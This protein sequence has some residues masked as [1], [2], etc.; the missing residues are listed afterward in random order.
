M[1]AA[2]L[3]HSKDVEEMIFLLEWIRDLGLLKNHRALIC[4]DA[5][6]PF[7]AVMRARAIAGDIFGSADV[8]ANESPVDGWIE[9]PKSLFISVAKWARANHESF[10]LIDSDAIPIRTGWLDLIESDYRAVG[11]KYMGCLFA[12]DQPG[13]PK[14]L[15]GPCS[16]YPADADE[17]IPAI[18]IPGRHWD[19]EMQPIIMRSVHNSPLIAHLFGEMNNPPTFARVANPAF[20]IFSLDWLNPGTM[21]FHR[22]KDRTL[23]NLLRERLGKPAVVS[24]PSTNGYAKAFFQMGRYGDLILLLPAFQEW[25]RRTGQPTVVFTSKEFGDIFEGVSYVK[26][27]KLPHNWHLQA[28]EAYRHAQTI[29]PDVI[30]IQL[31]GVG[32]EPA[33]PDSLPSYSISMWE[34]AGLMDDYARLPLV[35]D[36]R[37]DER[38]AALL[39]RWHATQKPMLLLNFH[40]RTSPFEGRDTLIPLICQ[41]LG[42]KFEFVN[43]NEVNAHRIF[44]LLGLMDAAAGLITVDTATL[45]LA[46]GSKTPYV[47]LVRG[48]GQSGSVPKGNVALRVTYGEAIKRAQEICDV[49]EAWA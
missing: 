44:D 23:I 33:K 6:T 15:M 11:K 5:A 30:R 43:T 7:S 46:A 1:T 10:L 18:S 12:C 42:G 17:L 16:V 20:G 27:M 38:E 29:Y 8:I 22:N 41:R 21:L 39:K 3:C 13:L 45:H 9:G 31:H 34:R 28:G 26:P 48:D 35:F 19:V 40:G 24:Q 49:M 32:M 14:L 25:A 4:A 36:R 47:A 2:F 37:S